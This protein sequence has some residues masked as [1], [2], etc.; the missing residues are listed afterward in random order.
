MFRSLEVSDV[1]SFVKDKDFTT[2]LSGRRGNQS[3]KG[4]VDVNSI[5]N[6]IR[7]EEDEKEKLSASISHSLFNLSQIQ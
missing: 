1:K 2:I 7:S 4:G 6:E 3:F 5:C